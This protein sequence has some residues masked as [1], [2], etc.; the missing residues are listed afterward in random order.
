MRSVFTIATFVACQ[1]A[2]AA[3]ESTRVPFVKGLTTVRAAT[4]PVG[5]YE[6]LRTVTDISD[7]SYRIVTS[8]EAPA[9]SGEGLVPVTVARRV[10]A[11]DQ[12]HS[13]NVRIAW[14][15]DD[16]E[17]MTGNT[18]GI[19]CDVFTEL[20]TA[21]KSQIT[22]LDLSIVGG[23]PVERRKLKGTLAVVDR[24]PFTVLVNRKPVA[25]PALHV[26]GTLSDEEGSLPFEFNVIDDPDNPLMLRAK[27]THTDAR[28]MSIEFPP[29][30]GAL[31]RTLATTEVVELSG[32][33]FSFA[34]AN[35]RPESDVTLTQLAEVL[36]T[37]PDW[38]FRID[39]HTDSIGSDASNLDLSK[40]RS[41]AVRAALVQRF[42]VPATQ[43]TTEGFGESKP[44][45]SN[46]TD[47]G[48]A[49]NRRV[50]LVRLNPT[51][52]GGSQQKAPAPS[53][54]VAGSACKFAGA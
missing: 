38:K 42:G 49:R 12:L 14:H 13:R 51:S 50:E 43:V 15:S 41:A 4:S 7:K 33:Y 28:V 21:G 2:C 29:A 32:V 26:A 18:P 23:F 24:T 17:S 34:S 8:G 36:K 30:E 52:A 19:S 11:T 20:R 40:R 3:D 31:E 46:D 45:A 1:L 54:N 48:R 27:Y 9:D 37:H 5:D 47:D 44:K 53:A 39:G 25:L 10:R 6:T 22:L 16:R 35:L